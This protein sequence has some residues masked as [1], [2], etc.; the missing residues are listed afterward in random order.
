MKSSSG[1]IYPSTLF[2]SLICLMVIGHS[3]CAFISE[4]EASKLTRD[5]YFRQNL[6][7]NGALIAIHSITKGD[8]LVMTHQFEHGSVQISIT[9]EKDMS[10]VQLSAFS[11][12]GYTSSASF[13]FDTNE[14]KIIQW[15]EP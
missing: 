1:Y 5:F 15:K 13:L 2:L 14:R 8:G 4:L 9:Q 12:S 7:Q 11:E 6:L 3:S 10:H